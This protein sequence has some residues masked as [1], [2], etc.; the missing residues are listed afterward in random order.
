M[1]C[2]RKPTRK[3]G[4]FAVT[5]LLLVLLYRKVDAAA[6]R[7]YL[8]DLRY[9][10]APFFFV[11]AFANTYLSAKRWGLLLEA[12]GI[13]IPTRKLFT[14]YY[15]GSFF[16][17]FLPSNIGGDVYRI[18]DVAKKSGTSAGSLASVVI[19]RLVGFI[20]MSL[21]GFILPLAG[22]PQVPP[23]HRVKLFIPLIVFFGFLAF[24]AL[25]WQK[26]LLYA[27]MRMC[28]PSKIR[29][30][31][32]VKLDEFFASVRACGGKRGTLAKAFA[33]SLLFQALVF[34]AIWVTALSLR[35]PV[36]LRQCFA[37]APL[38][39][40]LESMPLSINGIGLRDAGYVMFFTAAGV[41]EPNEAAAA[42]SICYVVFTLIYALGGGAL[43]LRRLHANNNTRQTPDETP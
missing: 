34:T 5:A 20:A 11:I 14:S 35:I 8:C 40:I 28:L 30:K 33:I 41:T 23:E 19:D 9:G 6:V 1:R 12:D 25:L 43:F 18:A 29:A 17:L 13:R 16:N 36:T 37:F 3:F 22:L 2:M 32:L 42:I 4:R 38:V 7:T 39:C 21:L 10:I 15:I 24:A 26:T 31:A 27:A